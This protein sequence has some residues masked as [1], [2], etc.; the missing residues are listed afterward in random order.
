MTEMQA[1][2]GCRALDK[3]DEWLSLRHRNARIL[4]EALNDIPA[5]RITEPP[6]HLKHAYYKYYVF[7]RPERLKAG[8]DRRRI[9]RCL[10]DLGVPGL[11]GTCGEIYLEKA[12]K[13]EGLGP[14]ERLSNAV[15]LDETGL[16]FL[17]HPTLQVEDMHIMADR[18]RQVFDRASR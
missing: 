18:I 6:P 14:S 12:F 7:L 4:T 13:A 15:L 1:V 17:V 11:T 5:L 8:W 3:L 16:M 2:L 9:L 10:E